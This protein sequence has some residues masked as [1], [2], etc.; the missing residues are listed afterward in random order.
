MDL[1]II[2]TRIEFVDNIL[3][4]NSINYM[5]VLFCLMVLLNGTNFIDGLNGLV[6]GYYLIVSI[7]LIKIDFFNF[8][9][10]IENKLFMYFLTFLIMWFANITRRGFLGDSGSYL[11]SAIFGVLVISFHQTHTTISPYYFILLLWYPCFE[12]LFSIIRKFNSNLSP[13]F[14]DNN[15]FHQLVFL[16]IKEKFKLNDIYANNFSSVIILLFTS[17]FILLGSTN[18]NSTNLQILLITLFTVFYLIFYQFLLNY[19]LNLKK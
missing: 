16:L 8:F 13:T 17:I 2:D 14:P 9:Q 15:H 12:N 6:I 19:K 7:V 11:L 3:R 10:L 1:K 4:F 5:F 18:S